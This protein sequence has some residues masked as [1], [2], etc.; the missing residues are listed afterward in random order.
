MSPLYKITDVVPQEETLTIGS[1]HYQDL[2]ESFGRLIAACARHSILMNVEDA[3][4][5]LTK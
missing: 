2:I 5:N 4:A 3:S 1:A